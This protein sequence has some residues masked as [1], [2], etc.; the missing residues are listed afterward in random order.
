MTGPDSLV[1]R[2]RTA[3]CVHA[4][5]EAAALREEYGSGAPLEAAV[6]RRVDGEPLEHVLGH[7]WFAGQRITVRPGVFVPRVRAEPLARLA[8]VATLAAAEPTTV[9]DLGC[10]SGAIAAV[11][12]ARAPSAR[13]LAVDTDEAAVECA[14][15]NAQVWDFETAQGDW[16]AA[17]PAELQGS[18]DVVVTY[19]PHV[20]TDR[21]PTLPQ[22]WLRHEGR[23]TVDGGTDGLEPLRQVL[24]Q[25]DD[26][27]CVDGLLLTLVAYHQLEA[28]AGL[29]EQAEWSTAYGAANGDGLLAIGRPG[30]PALLRSLVG[31]ATG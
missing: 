13:V 18:V 8:V 25:L 12:A 20:P 21:V 26:W 16:L 27:L 7:A 30:Q 24:D 5:D 4:E 14:A 3:G 9:V 28:A 23:A 10:G 6:A 22:D 11:V 29:A 17:A 2:L 1:A 31:S 19:L 15:A